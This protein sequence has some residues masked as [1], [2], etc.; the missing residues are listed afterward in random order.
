[1]VTLKD[2]AHRLKLKVQPPYQTPLFTLAV[3]IEDSYTQVKMERSTFKR[4]TRAL[5][6]GHVPPFLRLSILPG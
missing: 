4:Q 6:L 3:K 5:I 1:M 2:F